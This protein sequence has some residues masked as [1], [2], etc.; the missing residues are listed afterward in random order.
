M[1]VP[2]ADWLALREPADAAARSA[3]LTRVIADAVAPHDPV[4]IL[5][6]AT[7]TGA[8]LRYL[9]ERLPPHQA[10]LIADVDPNVLARVHE[11]T[12]SW[13]A[14]RGY[15]VERHANGF[16]LRG[17]KL[18]CS[19]AVRQV[20]L[21]ALP[22]ELFAGRHLVTASAL[23]DLVSEDWL[24]RLAQRCRAERAAA[25]FALN[26][27][28]RSSCEPAEPE[29]DLL[30]DGL[31][32]HQ[33]NDK[34]LGGPAAG[35]DADWIALRVF[36]KA[37]FV[38]RREPADWRLGAVHAELQRQLMEGWVQATLEIEPSLAANVAS[39]RERRFAHLAA[40]RSSVTV[41]HHDVAAWL[42]E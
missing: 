1:T 26:Y 25:L 39:W 37:G 8:N 36:E 12:A 11:R 32:R 13:A 22:S 23:L 6:L 2:L 41:G 3:A 20:N 16:A 35:P 21:D 14:E 27:D 19:V 28:G 34:G 38:A 33:L 30:R 29:D 31:N 15:T 9:A 7:G 42:P 4:R 10:W 5:D 40:G 18:D 24:E 17:A